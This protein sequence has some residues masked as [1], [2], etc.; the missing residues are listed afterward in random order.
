M[1]NK[2]L[3]LK[4]PGGS[5]GQAW[6]LIAHVSCV[7]TAASKIAALAPVNGRLSPSAGENMK[8][9]SRKTTN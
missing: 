7:E 8:M 3:N 2:S 9:V 5:S 6:P 4:T 1:K